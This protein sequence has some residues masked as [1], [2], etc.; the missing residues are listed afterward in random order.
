MLK[1]LPITQSRASITHL[2]CQAGTHLERTIFPSWQRRSCWTENLTCWDQVRDAWRLILLH[3]K[4]GLC[5][6]SA[7][8]TP[9][10][11]KGHAVCVQKILSEHLRAELS[12]SSFIP[13]LKMCA[14]GTHCLKLVVT[15]S[16]TAEMVNL[17]LNTACVTLIV[18]KLCTAEGCCQIG[19][20]VWLPALFLSS[21]FLAH[22]SRRFCGSEMSFENAWKKIDLL[23]YVNVL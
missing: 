5:S 6:C 11:S 7:D 20:K 18:K 4:E 14:I 23:H 22:Q 10:L 16:N 1:Q 3:N 2:I 12:L 13:I 21:F 19:R 8:S 9:I 17:S 15:G